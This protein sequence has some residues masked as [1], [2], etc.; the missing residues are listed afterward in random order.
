MEHRRHAGTAYVV[1][2]DSGS[3][4]GVLVLHSWWGLTDGVRATADALADTGFVAMAPD[5]FGVAAPESAAE[6]EEVQDASDPNE[7]AALILSAA[8]ALHGL[9]ATTAPDIGLVGFSSGA[10]WA[11]WAATRAPELVGAVVAYYGTTDV[12]PAGGRAAVLLHLADDDHLVA[13][14]DR[15]EMEAHLH[16]VRREVEVHQHEGT[17]HWFAEPGVDAFAADR[18]AEAWS[19]TVAFLHRHLDGHPPASD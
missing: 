5:L 4:P 16:I 14:D 9:P 7:V 8:S 13:D 6:A 12:D 19:Q 3:G 1:A 15:V 17:T 18:A 2:P 10:S 11:L